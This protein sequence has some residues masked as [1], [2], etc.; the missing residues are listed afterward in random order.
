MK[1]SRNPFEQVSLRKQKNPT[2]LEEVEENSYSSESDILNIFK[3]LDKNRSGILHQNN[4]QINHLSEEIKFIFKPIILK[5]THKNEEYDLG[6][7]VDEA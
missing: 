5:I 6:K 2:I 3:K 7:F 4:C 1:E